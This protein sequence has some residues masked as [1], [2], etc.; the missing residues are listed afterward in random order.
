MITKLYDKFKKFLKENYI[1][2]I[3]LIVICAAFFIPVPYYI[4]N[5]GGTINISDRIKIND[6]ED[7]QNFFMCYVSQMKSNIITLGLS[8]I[9]DSIDKEKI[10]DSNYNEEEDLIINNILLEESKSNAVINAFTKAGK[11]ISINSQKLY[12]THI[13]EEAKTNLEV[14]DEIISINDSKITSFEDMQ[15]IISNHNYKDKLTFNVIDYKG[16][17]KNK[18]AYVV[19]IDNEKKVGISLTMNYEYKIEDDVNIKFKGNETGP[20]G[21]LML[22]LAIYDSITNSNLSIDKKVCGTGTIT[23]DGNVGEI[24]GIKYKL[25]GA[26]KDEC[27]IFITPTGNNYNEAIKEKEKN[28]YDID[29]YEAKNF[30]DVITYLENY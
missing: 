19:N 17:E 13:F 9:F 23:S 1:S 20:S 25:N 7:E 16:K 2:I 26:V 15:K 18:E 6:N 10:V 3:I 21:G 30:T 4:Y 28:K 27:D 24:G 11:N 29:I 5:G 14:G 12:V 8:Y 22:S